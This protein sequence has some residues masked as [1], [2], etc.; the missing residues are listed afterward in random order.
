MTDTPHIGKEYYDSSDYFQGNADHLQDMESPFQRYRVR[1]VLEIHEPGSEP[2]RFEVDRA[3]TVNA[4]P[5]AFSRSWLMAPPPRPPSS[6][7]SERERGTPD[8][9]DPRVRSGTGAPR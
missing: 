9:P 3:L 6:E 2:I 7:P 1:K 5:Q 4:V 8:P